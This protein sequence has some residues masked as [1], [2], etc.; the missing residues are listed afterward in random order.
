M[1]DDSD[2]GEAAAVAIS[3]L[4]DEGSDSGGRAALAVAAASTMPASAVALD[5]GLEPASQRAERPADSQGGG[6]GGRNLKRR[7]AVDSDS[8]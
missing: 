2:G 4:E 7:V 5:A 8:D 1:G 3:D 6:G